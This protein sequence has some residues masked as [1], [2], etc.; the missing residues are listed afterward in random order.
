MKERL[1]R[2]LMFFTFLFAIWVTVSFAIFVRGDEKFIGAVLGVGAI[3]VASA[4]QY[5]AIAK[6]HP[7]YLFKKQS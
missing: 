3:L 6:W 4:I 5:I 1:L 2:V 7:L